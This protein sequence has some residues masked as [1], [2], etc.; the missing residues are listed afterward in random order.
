MGY[1]GTHA[2]VARG[3]LTSCIEIGYICAMIINVIGYNLSPLSL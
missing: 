3:D 1:S 2:I